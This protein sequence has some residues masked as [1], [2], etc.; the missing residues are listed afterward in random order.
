MDTVISYIEDLV[1]RFPGSKGYVQNNK[2]LKKLKSQLSSLEDDIISMHEILRIPAKRRYVEMKK[3]LD[4]MI[5]E[6]DQVVTRIKKIQSNIERVNSLKNGQSIRTVAFQKQ[7]VALN[8]I[9]NDKDV[10]IKNLKTKLENLE[11]INRRTIEDASVDNSRIVKL[12]EE[13]KSIL[14]EIAKENDHPVKCLEKFKNYMASNDYLAAYNEAKKIYG[15]VKEV[16]YMN[17]SNANGELNQLLEEFLEIRNSLTQKLTKDDYKINPSKPQ[18]ERLAWV[19]RYIDFII[20]KLNTIKNSNAEFSAEV[21]KASE[22]QI[23]SL[24]NQVEFTN[25]EMGTDSIISL[26]DKYLNDIKI[27][28]NMNDE[29]RNY[30]E[31]NEALLASYRKEAEELKLVI[32]V[33][34]SEAIDEEAKAKDI[35]ERDIAAEKVISLKFRVSFDDTVDEVFNKFIAEFERVL[36][37]NVADLENNNVALDTSVEE[38]NV[39][40]EEP[41]LETDVNKNNIEEE[42]KTDVV[43]F[44]NSLKIDVQNS[45]VEDSVAEEKIIEDDIAEEKNIGDVKPTFDLKSHESDT[46]TNIEPTYDI[47]ELTGEIPVTSIMDSIVASSNEGALVGG[48]VDNFLGS[49]NDTTRDD[50][51]VVE[52]TPLEVPDFDPNVVNREFVNTDGESLVDVPSV[53]IVSN[54]NTNPNPIDWSAFKNA[55]SIEEDKKEFKPIDWTYQPDVDKSETV[56][57][58]GDIKAVESTQPVTVD[59]VVKAEPIVGI[60]PVID[61]GEDTSGGPE[62]VTPESIVDVKPAIVFEP[63]VE[64]VVENGDSVITFETPEFNK[65]NDVILPEIDFKPEFTTPSYNASTDSYFSNNSMDDHPNLGRKPFSTYD[66]GEESNELPFTASQVI[67]VSKYGEPSKEEEIISAPMDDND[68]IFSAGFTRKLSNGTLNSQDEEEITFESMSI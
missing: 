36:Q 63:V 22:E 52:T 41:I 15:Q 50:V 61:L 27:S 21:E 5:A 20:G 26:M 34:G 42:S 65:S 7:I 29:D 23:E 45:S 2:V 55:N 58:V 51:E 39:S 59:P 67:G 25:D 10:E 24:E 9:I 49:L 19:N 35:E 1:A 6:K 31:T 54:I 3:V 33:R 13:E 30:I 64:P 4:K 47:N 60:Q 38:D 16:S 44:L 57:S 56:A 66:D 48:S 53:D 14:N 43:E 37:V 46:I 18:L 40:I 32:D 28:N 68:D 62:P 8:R 12:E 17:D 11:R